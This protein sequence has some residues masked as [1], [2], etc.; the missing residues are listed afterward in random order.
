MSDLPTDS[1]V[2][3]DFEQ[4]LISVFSELADLFGN[5]RSHGQVYG[6]LFSSPVPL[7]MEEITNRIGLSMGS[8]SIGLRALE[9]LGAV[10]RQV[11]GKFG[12][13]TAKL[14]LKTLISGFV[15]QRLVPRLEKSNGTLKE[16]SSL[17]DQMPEEQAKEAGYRL[18]R[19]TQWHTRASQFL[20]L[21]EKLL[22][23]K[24]DGQN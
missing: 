12:V 6:I 18:K 21:A 3:Q 7:T 15:R 11:S 2:W 14:E 16:L 24:R 19:V 13:Y 17:I 22:G 4:G 1:E 8:V 23:A 9:E 10:E 5:P 20:P